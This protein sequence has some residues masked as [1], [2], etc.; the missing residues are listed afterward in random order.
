MSPKNSK[1]N[2]FIK[3]HGTEDKVKNAL[4]IIGANKL[5]KF[6]FKF[7][8]CGK[9]YGQSFNEWQE[10]GILNDLN[11]KF[12]DF[13]S[14]SID[15]LKKSKRLTVYPNY[16][17]TSLFKKPTCF[18]GFN[19]QW[20]RLRI[21]GRRRLIG[22]FFSDDESVSNVF[23]VVFLDENHQFYPTEK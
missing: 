21:T 12:H 20:A 11:N 22:V 5:I 1:K 10:K 23:F 2:D 16:P 3:N 13:S 15:E 18:N 19:V 17:A 14:F 7:F 9:D 6:N 4:G 8:L